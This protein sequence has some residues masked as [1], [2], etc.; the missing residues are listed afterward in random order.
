MKTLLATTLFLLIA[1]CGFSTS[2]TLAQASNTHL[3]PL[4]LANQ[5]PEQSA[6]HGQA[7]LQTLFLTGQSCKPSKDTVSNRTL[8]PCLSA[9][10]ASGSYQSQLQ[11]N[12]T[13]LPGWH[14]SAKQT[15]K[16]SQATLAMQTDLSRQIN[17]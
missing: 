14:Y 10:P 1:L 6:E 8:A 2:A 4:S 5:W 13:S 17:F 16:Y 7:L 12:T 15:E 3:Q 9:L 11:R